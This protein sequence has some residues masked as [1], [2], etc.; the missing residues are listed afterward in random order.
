MTRP[1][2]R[3]KRANV[4]RYAAAVSSTVVHRRKGLLLPR[5]VGGFI[6][7]HP[8]FWDG[9]EEMSNTFRRIGNVLE[10]GLRKRISE[11]KYDL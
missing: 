5:F 9:F 1:R 10:R 7:V 2:G 3:F 11:G 6:P 8:L 4:L